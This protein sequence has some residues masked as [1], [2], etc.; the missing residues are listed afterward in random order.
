MKKQVITASIIILSFLVSLYAYP[1]L[2]ETMAT[3]WN[4]EGIV[5][6]YSSKTFGL[7]SLPVISLLLFGLF[8]ILPNFDPLKQNVDKFRKYYDEFV[9]VMI[10]FLFYLHV[11]SIMQNVGLK[12]NMLV[13]TIP[14]FGLVFYYVGTLVEN[15]KRN[16]FIGIKTPWTLSDE[17]VWEKT[18]KMGGKL[19]KYSALIII[20]GMIFDQYAI[21]FIL[22]PAILVSLYLTIYSY[23]EYQKVCNKQKSKK[24]KD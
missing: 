3:H 8:N 5:D 18:H 7:F 22:L 11:L 6:N 12:F 17:L 21:W 23:L 20:G 4:A 2:P 9:M 19:Y 10:W 16:W 13:F 24:N 1:K 14:A 15:A